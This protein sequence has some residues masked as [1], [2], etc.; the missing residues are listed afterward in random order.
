MRKRI[1]LHE[2]FN[3]DFEINEIMILLCSKIKDIN[4]IPGNTV[5]IF[6]ELQ[7]CPSARSSLKYFIYMQDSGLFVSMLEE[8]TAGDILTGNLGIYKGAI[9]ENY[10]KYKVENCIKLSEQN[11]GFKNNILTISY[12]LVF[13]INEY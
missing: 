12:Y 8:G 10:E 2:I 4:L 3:G 9:F 11:I 6:D 7:D 1:D 5:L 13:L